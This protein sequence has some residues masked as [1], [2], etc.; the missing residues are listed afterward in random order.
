M[1]LHIKRNHKIMLLPTIYEQ[2]A[3]VI[4]ELRKIREKRKIS[5]E[6]MAA[7]MNTSVSAV[8]RLENY[9]GKSPK[10]LPRLDT[11][12]AYALSLNSEI[13]IMYK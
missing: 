8:S 11:I 12:D 9:N 13:F 3:V 6:E 1:K 4:K 5:Q 7:M 2:V 10:K